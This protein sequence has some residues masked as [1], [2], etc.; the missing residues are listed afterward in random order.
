MPPA[1]RTVG[2]GEPAILASR[3]LK[4]ALQCPIDLIALGLAAK[5]WEPSSILLRLSGQ[6]LL[7][8]HSRLDRRNKRKHCYPVRDGLDPR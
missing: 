2:S 4:A 8:E 7:Q 1:E 6:L 3:H 5:L